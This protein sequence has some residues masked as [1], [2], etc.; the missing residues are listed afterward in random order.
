MDHFVNPMDEGFGNPEKRERAI[1]LSCRPAS[2]QF[3]R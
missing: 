3:L 1:V 2:E